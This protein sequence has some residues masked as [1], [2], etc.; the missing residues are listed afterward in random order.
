MRHDI[1]NKIGDKPKKMSISREAN[2][3]CLGMK[4]EKGS[5]RPS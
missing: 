1:I 4:R 3:R 5:R 2:F